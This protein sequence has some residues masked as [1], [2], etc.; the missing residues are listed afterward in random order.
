MIIAR[1]LPLK[2]RLP[3]AVTTAATAKIAA[4]PKTP[5][6]AT[7]KDCDQLAAPRIASI[8][9]ARTRSVTDATEN[10]IRGVRTLVDLPL[11]VYASVVERLRGVV[12]RRLGRVG[13][14][15]RT[16][17]DKWRF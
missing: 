7:P 3:T 5:Y 14:R 2:R 10:F 1:R 16:T 8:T 12:E 4:V 9:A 15:A 13:Q 17:P 6:Q 11:S